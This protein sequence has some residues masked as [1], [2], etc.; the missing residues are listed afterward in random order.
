MRSLLD[1]QSDGIE[2]TLHMHGISATVVGGNISPRLIQYHVKLEGGVKFSHVVELSEELAV[3]LKVASVRISRD[4]QNI[5]IEVPRP[6]PVA[7]RLFPLMRSLPDDLPENAPI[8]GLDE[9]GVPLLVRLAAPDIA[10][11]LISGSTGSGK[12]VLARSMIASLALQN[13]PDRLKLL[14]ID[15]RGRGYRHYNGL[16]N[17]VCPIVTDPTDGLH[18]LKWAARHIEKRAETGNT[19]PNLVVFIDELA[20][21]TMV[22][23]RE[24]EL[25]INYLLQ[26]GREAGIHLVACTQKPA[27]GMLAG[28]VRGSFPTRIVG[29]VAT[30]DE[31]RAAS[32][33]NNSG[34][35]RLMGKGDFLLFTQGESSRLQAAHI[36]NVE[37]E[38]T[39]AHL[40]G[41]VQQ[42]SSKPEQP[43]MRP[44]VTAKDYN[45][46][47]DRAQPQYQEEEDQNY[48]Q[49][50]AVGD[51]ARNY[52]ENANYGKEAMGIAERLATYEQRITENRPAAPATDNMP[53]YNPTREPKPKKTIRA[54]V[55]DSEF[56][57]L[58]DKAQKK[59]SSPRSK[60]S[61]PVSKTVN[62]K[63][64]TTP[65]SEPKPAESPK[66]PENPPPKPDSTMLMENLRERL[67]ASVAKTR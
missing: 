12:S 7:V 5:K 13:P 21:L 48:D 37:M 56:E 52:R 46:K 38:Q 3:A 18:R 24:T 34:A 41:I 35:E 20:D 1:H 16:P 30:L 33:L 54:D 27:S 2:Y 39:V 17:L 45:R 42:P 58:D 36:S 50:R 29:K 19:V 6:D 26:G 32:G 53:N 14:L 43:A 63:K 8:L 60:I 23:A 57:E 9:D 62:E 66:S 67:K 11:I 10:H 61:A 25:L 59:T 49:R 55:T 47:F 4:A 65:T 22:N 51:N 64:L 44:D 31:A 40:G 15:P 28:V